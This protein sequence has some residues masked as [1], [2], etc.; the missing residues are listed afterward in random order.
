MMEAP[1]DRF[2]PDREIHRIEVREAT[3]RLLDVEIP[4]FAAS[5]DNYTIEDTE[6]L[7]KGFIDQLHRN[8]IK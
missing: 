8:G 1:F 2:D 6:N 4:R 7:E 5:F 3:A